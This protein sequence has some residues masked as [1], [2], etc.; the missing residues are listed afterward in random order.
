MFK[1]ITN[2]T[3]QAFVLQCLLD[4]GETKGYVF[5]SCQH[6]KEGK[7]KP[8]NATGLDE[9]IQVQRASLSSISY[10]KRKKFQNNKFKK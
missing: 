6:R 8:N 2:K 5:I 10:K 7:K 9:V 3:K 1:L 4:L